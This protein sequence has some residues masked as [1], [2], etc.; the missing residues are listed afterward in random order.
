[1]LKPKTVPLKHTH[2]DTIVI[3]TIKLGKMILLHG[4]SNFDPIE[5]DSVQILN[6]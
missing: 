6:S 5:Y 3:L 1:M 4:F 2:I